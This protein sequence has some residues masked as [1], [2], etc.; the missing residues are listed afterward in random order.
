MPPKIELPNINHWVAKY[1]AGMSVNQISKET[2]IGRGPITKNLVRQGVALRTQSQAE[3]AKWQIIKQTA[4][5]IERQLSA[6]W[7]AADAID[8]ELE[9][10]VI[11]LYTTTH[12]SKQRLADRFNCHKS[13]I[14]RILRKNNITNSRPKVRSAT[15]KSITGL[16]EHISFC[17]ADLFNALKDVGAD[18]NQQTAIID[19]NVDFT[20]GNIA[21]E[22]ERRCPAGSKSLT[23]ERLKKVFSSGYSVIVVYLPQKTVDIAT[24]NWSAVAQDVIANINA[25]KAHPATFG[26]Y[27]V[28]SCSTKGLT[29]VCSKFD[30]YTFVATHDGAL[31]I[32]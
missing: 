11:K 14:S 32:A 5:G 8:D 9:A 1:L 17:E 6:A 21:I 25:I 18:V 19:I 2:G 15:T 4:G 16:G 23:E 22:L 31:N 24:V 7:A 28:T 3:T 30:G 27:G 13:N 20:I 10:E 29:A 12:I 26:K